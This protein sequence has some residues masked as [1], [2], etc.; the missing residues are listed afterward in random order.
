MISRQREEI[1]ILSIEEVLA[2]VGTSESL[3]S[4]A[5]KKNDGSMMICPQIF[6]QRYP[7]FLRTRINTDKAVKAQLWALLRYKMVVEK[8]LDLGMGKANTMEAT[9]CGGAPR[10]KV[11]QEL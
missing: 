9:A 6:P 2:E 7:Q 11:F 1:L 10:W 5:K 3:D 8:A 4:I